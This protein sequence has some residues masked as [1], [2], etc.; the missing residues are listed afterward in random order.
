MA[1]Y[2]RPVD[3]R[4]RTSLLCGAIAIIIAASML[5]R[6]RT[7]RAQIFFALFSFDMGLWYLAQWLYHFVHQALWWRFTAVLAILLP[8]F[9]VHLFEA[10]FPSVGGKATLPRVAGALGV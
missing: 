4:T 5:L 3:L 7:R 8:Q 2:P 6:G 1:R 9:A 10:I